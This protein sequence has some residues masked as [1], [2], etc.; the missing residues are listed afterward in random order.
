MEEKFLWKDVLQETKEKGKYRDL[1]AY[2]SRFSVVDGGLKAM[3]IVA[4]IAVD[5]VLTE[6]DGINNQSEIPNVWAQVPGPDSGFS[7]V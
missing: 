7:R 3:C 5:W 6:C 1:M 2:E 4:A